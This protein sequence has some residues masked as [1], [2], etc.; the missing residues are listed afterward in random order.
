M[1]LLDYVDPEDASPEVRNLLEMDRSDRGSLLRPMLANHPP[2]LEA[3]MHYHERLMEEGSLDRE[4]K[5]LVGVVVSQANACDYCVSSH[6]EKLH[7]LGLSP[8]ALDA[9]DGS[10]FEGMSEHEQVVLAFAERV[11]ADAHRIAAADLDGLRAVG[12]DDREIVELLGVVAMFM[13]ANT[14]ANALSIHPADRD[15]GLD[16]Y[17][18]PSTLSDGE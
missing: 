13:A 4:L 9:V 8:A 3:Q 18:E 15:V 17:L 14:L 6:R 10:N 11:A 16:P 1:A 7:T 5:E 2:L 12:F